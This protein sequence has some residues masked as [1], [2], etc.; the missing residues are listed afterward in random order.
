MIWTC[1]GTGARVAF[2]RVGII[3]ITAKRNIEETVCLPPVQ[4]Q[5]QIQIS[6]QYSASG[7]IVILIGSKSTKSRNEIANAAGV[8]KKA[9][10]QQFTRNNLKCNDLH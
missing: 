2:L 6:P 10:F 4:N 5:V 3:V 1:R 9:H 8:F 7:V